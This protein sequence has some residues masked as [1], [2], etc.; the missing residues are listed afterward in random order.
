M[1]LIT[2]LEN[3]IPGL[4][5]YLM[6]ARGIFKTAVTRRGR[7]DYDANAVAEIDYNMEPLKPYLNT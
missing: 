6:K 5:P 3:H 1:M 4:R 2:N 7:F